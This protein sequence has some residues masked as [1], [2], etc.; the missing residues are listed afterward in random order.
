MGQVSKCCPN[1]V[2]ARWSSIPSQSSNNITTLSY[3]QPCMNLIVQIYKCCTNFDIHINVNHILSVWHGPNQMYICHKLP[4]REAFYF[5]HSLS[6]LLE[7]KMEC[8]HLK[9]GASDDEISTSGCNIVSQ[10]G[11]GLTKCIPATSCV[12]EK[13]FASTIHYRY[14][15][16]YRWRKCDQLMLLCS[17][18]GDIHLDV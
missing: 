14:S 15:C 1:L 8:D 12:P 11:L 18:C 3:I 13:L 9:R 17:G 6:I 5:H 7:L 16:T 4:S 2:Q 10:C